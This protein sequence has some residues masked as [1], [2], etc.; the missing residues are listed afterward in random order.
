MTARTRRRSTGLGAS[1]SR[2]NSSAHSSSL[3]G[4]SRSRPSPRPQIAM[5]VSPANGCDSRFDRGTARTSR[6]RTVR[7]GEYTDQ[8]Y[9]VAAD[10]DPAETVPAWGCHGL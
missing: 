2:T 5:Q 3:I 10:M 7:P 4:S 6:T 8:L 9:G 1:R